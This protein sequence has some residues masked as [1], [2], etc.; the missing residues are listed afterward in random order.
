MYVLQP[1]NDARMTEA[2]Y[3]DYADAQDAKQEYRA[4]YVYAMVG[5]TVRHNTITA[6][7]IRVFGNDLLETDCTVTTADTRVHIA[8]KNAYRYP[9]ATVFCGEPSYLEG[10]SD[11]ITNP[12]LLVEVGSPSTLLVDRNEK[13][14]EYTS[15]DSLQA[16]LLVSQDEPKIERFVRGE[17]RGEWLYSSARGEDAAIEI[18]PLSLVISL[19]DVYRKVRWEDAG[20][21]EVRSQ[22]ES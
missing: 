17:R 13:L 7:V 4:G 5:G 2:E 21:D 1:E 18:A 9:D 19:A 14:E 15:I 10:C 22:A 20:D 16:Y 8:K 3:L 11:T 12:V 6:N